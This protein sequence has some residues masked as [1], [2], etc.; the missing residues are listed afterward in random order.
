MS[1]YTQLYMRFVP[2]HLLHKMLQNK[3]HKSPVLMKKIPER[4]LFYTIS[5]VNTKPKVK[6]GSL[7]RKILFYCL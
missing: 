2:E 5:V 7:I 4:F 1:N 6:F 3:V